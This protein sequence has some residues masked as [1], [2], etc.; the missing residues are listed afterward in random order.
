[1]AG[2]SSYAHSTLFVLGW[3]AEAACAYIGVEA[4]PL[5]QQGI[6]SW[7]TNIHVLSRQQP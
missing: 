6:K 4:N 5:I 3:K 1:M 7:G 2:V